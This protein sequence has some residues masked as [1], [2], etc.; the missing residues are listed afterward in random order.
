MS[1]KC[2]KGKQCGSV[3][4]DTPNRKVPEDCLEYYGGNLIAESI[5]KPEYVSLI[6]AA[7]DLLA[8]CEAGFNALYNLIQSEFA[9]IRNPNPADD[10]PDIAQMRAAIAKAKGEA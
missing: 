9:T 2:F 4:S 8:A 10:D 3:V 7:P 5:P 1:E 6:A